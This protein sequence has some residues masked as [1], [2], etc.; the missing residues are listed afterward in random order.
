MIS[1]RTIIRAA[2]LAVLAALPVRPGAA[3][4]GHFETKAQQAFMVDAETGT[5]LYSKD[6]DKLIPPASLA[7]L[8]TAEI[9]FNAVKS[10]QRSMDDTFMVSEHAWRTGGAP[11]RTATMFAA[12]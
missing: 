1:P 6:P 2:L 12:L 9:V 4:E 3:Q 5:A 7:K 8:M 11:S 10:G